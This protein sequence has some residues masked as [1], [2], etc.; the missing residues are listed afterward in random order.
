MIVAIVM[1]A[2]LAVLAIAFSAF[3]RHS[4]TPEW[5]DSELRKSV[6]RML[7]VIGPLWGMRYQEPR[8][9]PP[10]VTTPGDDHEPLSTWTEE[11]LAPPA[12][13]LR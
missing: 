12:P 2:I 1:A 4:R 6:L 5:G 9:T 10:A 7:V 13:S 11:A 3:Y 8:P